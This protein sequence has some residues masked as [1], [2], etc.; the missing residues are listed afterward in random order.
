MGKDT[1]SRTAIS[2]GDETGLRHAERGPTVTTRH[3]ARAWCESAVS[4]AS[5]LLLWLTLAVPDWIERIS[6]LDPDAH[7]G[8][9]ELAV[10]G[11]FL[12]TA[13]IFGVLARLEWSR[14]RM[15]APAEPVSS[16]QQR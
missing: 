16:S 12:L 10:V 6:G 2:R 8:S 9:V 1:S 4:A 14:P 7:N 5:A 15:G 3:A 11:L 13:I